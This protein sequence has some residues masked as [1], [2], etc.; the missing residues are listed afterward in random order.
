MQHLTIAEAAKAVGI[1]QGTFK[2]RLSRA[3][4]NL[5]KKLP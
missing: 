1:R 2:S 3:L 5:R 4:K